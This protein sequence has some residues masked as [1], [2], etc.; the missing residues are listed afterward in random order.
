MKTHLP[1][2]PKSQAGFSLL[3]VLVTI[4]VLSLGLLGFAGLQAYSLKS[5]RLALQRSLAT[6]QAYNIVDSMRANRLSAI[7][8][9]YNQDYVVTTCDTPTT[10][11][12]VAADDLAEWNAAL[13]CNL[14]SGQ[15]KITVTGTGNVTINI[16]WNEGMDT[17]GDFVTWSTETTL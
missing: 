13:A 5:N 16:K 15:G 8:S 14:P 9:Q 10:S 2:P 7:G 11:G 6:M 4:V 3:E 1:R 17:S 12:N